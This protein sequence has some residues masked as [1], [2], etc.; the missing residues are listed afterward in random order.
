MVRVNDTECRFANRHSGRSVDEHMLQ[1]LAVVL[2]VAASCQAFSPSIPAGGLRKSLPNVARHA[3]R[4]LTSRCVPT[5]VC[6][7]GDPS[8][9]PAGANCTAA[10]LRGVWR[11]CE[12]PQRREMSGVLSQGGFSAA[13]GPAAAMYDA[14]FPKS[15]PN[16]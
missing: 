3:G 6:R 7:M 8:P 2:A 13:G 16:A 9:A 14:V 5:I 10:Q 4:P 15:R 12:L 1:R 11:A